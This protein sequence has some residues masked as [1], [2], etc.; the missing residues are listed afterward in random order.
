MLEASLR[1]SGLLPDFSADLHQA[2]LE[3][4]V[5]QHYQET[6]MTEFDILHKRSVCEQFYGRMILSIT[7]LIQLGKRLLRRTTNGSWTNK[8]ME[9]IAQSRRSS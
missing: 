6:W 1:V 7:K 2:G 3:L 9:T 5:L 4:I 8:P